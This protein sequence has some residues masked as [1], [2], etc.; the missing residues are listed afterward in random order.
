MLVGKRKIINNIFYTA[1][2]RASEKIRIYWIQEVEV[3]V[4][5]RIK[6]WDISK[7][8]ELLKLDLTNETNERTRR[9]GK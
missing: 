8:V 3:K 9:L 2:T 6:Q 1:I 4:I 5:N 7:N